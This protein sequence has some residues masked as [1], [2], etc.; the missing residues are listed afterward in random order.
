M[1]LGEC[2]NVFCRR[3][4]LI[5]SSGD[6]GTSAMAWKKKRLVITSLVF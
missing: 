2:L 1:A 5:N 6:M 4:L 3:Q